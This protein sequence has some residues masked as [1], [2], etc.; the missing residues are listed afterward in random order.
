MSLFTIDQNKCMKDG[1]CAAECPMGIIALKEGH[2]PEPIDGAEQLCINC[3]HCVAVCP[4]GA[5]SLATMAATSCAPVDKDLLPTA[6]QLKHL[7]Q[8]RR[9][10]RVYK[11]K[12]VENEKL[13][14]IID[15]TRYAPTG[16]NTQLIS[17]LVISRKEMLA[18]LAEQTIDWMRHL[19]A[20][21]DPMAAA[22]GM[23]RV[24]S[25]WEQGFDP[26][27]RSAPCLI[28]MHAPKAYGGGVIDSTI[29][30]TTFELTAASEDLGT[31]W[32]GF[33]FLGATHWKPLQEMLELPAANTITGAMM[34]GYA[35]HRYQRIPLRNN[36]RVTW[37]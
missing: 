22:L 19:L 29:G 34:T 36:A 35:K 8:T 16:K 7:I 28:V 1:I 5:L 30:L 37:R 23:A 20:K 11:D 10:T 2:N 14:R 32:A 3:G 27:L 6:G 15:T 31:C 26:I 24:V 18:N 4:H 33:F 25:A 17:W 13:A 9:S 21:D 12:A